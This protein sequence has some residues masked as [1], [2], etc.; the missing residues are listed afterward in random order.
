MGFLMG[1]VVANMTNLHQRVLKSAWSLWV[2]QTQLERLCST[3]QGRTVSKVRVR[4][5][6]QGRCGVLLTVGTPTTC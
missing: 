6:G 4:V 3:Q 2:R 1:S 5:E